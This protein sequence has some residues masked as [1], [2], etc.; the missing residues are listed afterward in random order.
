MV[1]NLLKLIGRKL[2]GKSSS[3]KKE[4]KEIEKK[5]DSVQKKVQDKKNE[6]TVQGG[7]V[8]G[9]YVNPNYKGSNPR[10]YSLP[11]SPYRKPPQTDSVKHASAPKTSAKPLIKPVSKIAVKWNPD[12]FKVPVIEGKKR[13]HDFGLPEEIMHAIFDLNFQYCTPIQME[14]LGKGLEGKDA[15]GQAQTGTGKTAAFLITSLTRILRNKSAENKRPGSPRVLVLA[16]TRELAMQI[17]QDALLLSKYLNLNILT[18][19]G[20]MDYNKQRNYLVNKT[21]DILIGTPGRIIDFIN[22]HE[23][24]LNNVDTLVL[25]EADRMLDMGFIPDVKKIVR[26]C[27]PKE[28][29]QTLFFS[30]T[31]NTDVRNLAGSWTRDSFSVEIEPD[32]LIVKSI[33]QIVYIVSSREKYYLLY[34]ILMKEK[35]GKILVFVNRRDEARDLGRKLFRNGIECE[36]ISGE[37]DQRK[38]IKVLDNFKSSAVKVLIA[39]DV[40]G[41]GIHVDNISHVINFSLPG[42][43]QDYV[44]RIGRTGRAGA[45]GISISFATED[46]SFSIPAIEELIGKPFVCINPPEELLKQ[47]PPYEREAKKVEPV[48][49]NYPRP[50]RNYNRRK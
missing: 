19:F 12:E 20:G 38:R 3:K 31:I 46:D 5:K 33:E 45:T 40:A 48:K 13:F 50:Q 26:A 36:I 7:D 39:T 17:S 43:P 22:K 34:N 28:A 30:A 2:Q 6:V 1:L 37:V 44:H 21:V 32:E 14:I 41:R 10:G 29:R 49:S 47:P 27:P 8:K 18:V 35:P 25:D 11:R 9:S 15:I 4:L 23:L 16:P 24:H 42:D